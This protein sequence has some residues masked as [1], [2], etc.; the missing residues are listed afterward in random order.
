MTAR[1][2]LRRVAGVP[3]EA[4]AAATGYLFATLDW[5][6]PFHHETDNIGDL[7]REFDNSSDGEFP[8]LHL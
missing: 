2:M 4:Y 5:M 8:T 6:N 3:S 7:D 1:A